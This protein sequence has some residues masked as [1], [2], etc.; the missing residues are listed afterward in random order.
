MANPLEFLRGMKYPGRF[1]VL[2][3]SEN[4]RVAVYGITGRSPASRA[5]KLVTGDIDITLNNKAR[6][7][8]VE[9]TDS[10]ILK[11]GNP[12]LLI[13]PAMIFRNGAAVQ[14]AVVSN[15]IQTTDVYRLIST[16]GPAR[17]ILQAHADHSYEPDV[18]NYTPRI[19]GHLGRER[20]ALGMI[21][22]TLEGGAE[23]ACL[24]FPFEPG[25][26]RFIAT[27][28]GENANPLPS[29]RREPIT[30]RIPGK[31]PKETAQ[32]FYDA[33]SPTNGDPDYRVAIAVAYLSNEVSAQPARGLHIINRSEQKAA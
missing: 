24:E 26:G 12:K 6:G 5:R 33:L 16:N 10:E 19:S 11:Q 20:A 23:R 21:R 1:I 2:G 8:L 13:Y 22:R 3:M 31:N 32:A 14:E 30:I 7:I 9:P 15:G 4:E 25:S 27:Y 28:T 29:F 17:S 18:P